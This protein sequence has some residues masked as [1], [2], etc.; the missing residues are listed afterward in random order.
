MWFFDPTFIIL[1]PAI[2]ISFWAQL[3]VSSTFDKYSRVRSRNGYTGADVARMILDSADLRDVPI[4]VIP[5][6]LTDHYDPSS[7]VMR[8]SPEVFHG[9]SVSAIGVAAHESGHALQHKMNYAP[10]KIRN[11]IVPIVNFS[12]NASWIIFLIGI[13][14]SIPALAEIGV[15]LFTAVVVFQLITLPVEFNASK[16]AVNI[17]E[18]RAI[19]MGDEVKGAK[20]VLDAAAMTY[21]A[22]AL[23]AILNLVRLILI[24]R[25]DD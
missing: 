21:V 6:K 10:L 12:S 17:L 3:K 16:R 11:S 19:L 22:A 2:I 24:S 4:E 25:R 7:R 9:D 20:K 23:M 18:S 15:I 1:I 5:G 13:I 14:F 8:L